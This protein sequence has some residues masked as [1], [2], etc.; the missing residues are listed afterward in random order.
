MNY[1]VID[2]ILTEHYKNKNN[3]PD[4][5][6]QHEIIKN[7]SIVL[8]DKHSQDEFKNNVIDEETFRRANRP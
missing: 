8:E 6:R 3:A 1:T 4:Y 5:K 2:E 7:V